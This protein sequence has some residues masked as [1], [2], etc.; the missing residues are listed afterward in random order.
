MKPKDIRIDIDP[1]FINSP[2]HGNSLRTLLKQNPNGVSESIICR[3]LSIT[4]EEL[5]SIY[6]NAIMKLRSHLGEEND[7]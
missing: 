7:C 5:Q 3:V 4:P 6:L 2:K 1:D